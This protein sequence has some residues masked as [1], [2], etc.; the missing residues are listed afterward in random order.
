[1]KP[2]FSLTIMSDTTQREFIMTS[3]L[4]ALIQDREKIAKLN[5]KDFPTPIL[6]RLISKEC[7]R[8]DID[9]SELM[10]QMK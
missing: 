10:E 9:E 3:N 7:K 1:M 5:G 8:L 4:A 6:D 2:L